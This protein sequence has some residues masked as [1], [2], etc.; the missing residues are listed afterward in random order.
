MEG[1]LIEEDLIEI[2]LM[3]LICTQ[4]SERVLKLPNKERISSID[5]WLVWDIFY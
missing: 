1:M 3:L 5:W 2:M 4:R